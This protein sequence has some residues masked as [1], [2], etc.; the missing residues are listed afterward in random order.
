M[1]LFYFQKTA[2]ISYTSILFVFFF[3]FQMKPDN[4]FPRDICNICFDEIK[5]AYSFKIKCEKSESV[6]K[7]NTITRNY[8]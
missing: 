7:K 2:H 3:F 6:L 8:V 5:K 1:D 4:D